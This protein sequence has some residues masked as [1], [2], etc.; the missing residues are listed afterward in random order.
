MKFVFSFP[1]TILYQHKNFRN[2]LQKI[3][4]TFH[5]FE[6]LFNNIFPQ[7]V[8]ASVELCQEHSSQDSSKF[9]NFGIN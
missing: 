6:K 4:S 5:R 7:I 1:D 2:K 9:N 3:F 8:Y